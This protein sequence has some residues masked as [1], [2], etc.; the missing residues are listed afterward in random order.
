MYYPVTEPEVYFFE[1]DSLDDLEEYDYLRPFFMM[2]FS[3][4]KEYEGETENMSIQEISRRSV[5]HTDECGISGIDSADAEIVV[6]DNGRQVFLHAQWV[7]E[8][9]EEFLFETTYESTYD[10]YEKMFEPGC[11]ADAL[12]AERDRIVAAGMKESESAVKYPEQRDALIEMI[13]DKLEEH[14]IEIND[15]D[16]E[17]E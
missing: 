8:V 15:G 13:L 17:D 14:G 11:D 2:C 10:L 6:E 9:P 12:C 16:E 7:S 4:I 1:A 5:F 3:F